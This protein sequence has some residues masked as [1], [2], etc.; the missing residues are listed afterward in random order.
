MQGLLEL[1]LLLSGV[2]GAGLYIAVSPCLFPLLPLFLINNLQSTSSR[3]RSLLVTF[4][5]LLGILSSIALLIVIFK[6]V[7]FIGSFILGNYR[8]LQAVLGVLII[9]LG[10]VMLSSRLQD[11]L[12]LSSLSIKSQPSAPRNLLNVF[13]VGLGYSILAYPCSGTAIVGTVA[14]FGAG[15]NIFFD[16]F[17]FVVLSIAIAI[18]YLM[19]A[20]LTGEAR[21][22]MATS[23]RNQARRIEIITGV[24]LIFVGLY[25]VMQRIIPL[26]IV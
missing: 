6:V 25:L 23:I 11:I 5:L 10:I 19:I 4:A 15:A 12:H 24:I 13:S 20:L 18:P 14:I 2:F 16:I 17:L 7:G 21:L 26:L 8:T 1:G 9:V 3:S 22:K